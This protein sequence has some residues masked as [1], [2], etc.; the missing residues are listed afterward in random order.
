[1]H[2]IHFRKY[3]TIMVLCCL[4]I[5]AM[6]PGC[7]QGTWHKVQVPTNQFLH[8]VFFTDSLYGWA[9]GDSGTM[10]HTRDGG[11][12]WT[13]QDD[14]SDHDIM[15][16][17]FLNRNVGWASAYNFTIPPFGTQLLKTVNGGETWTREAY[18]VENIFITCINFLD[19]MN[20]WMG[21]RPHALVRTRDGG[22][23]WHQADIDTST[24]AFFPV[25]SITFFNEKYGWASG[26]MFDIAGV[27]W[28]TS[29]GGNRWFAIDVSEAPADEVHALHAFDSLNVMGAGGDPDFGY[30]VGIIRTSNSGVNWN[31]EELGMAGFAVD[32]DFRN[33]KEAW[34]PLGNRMKFIYSLDAGTTWKDVPTPDSTAIF[35]VSFPDSLHGFAVG[36]K[37]AFLRYKPA[38]VPYVSPVTGYPDGYR[39]EQNFPNPFMTSTTFSLSIP[40]VVHS[41]GL[42]FLADPLKIRISDLL[43]NTVSVIDIGKLSPGDHRVAFSRV[44]MPDGVYICCLEGGPG[45]SVLL[46]KPLRMLVL[47]IDH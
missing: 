1:M 13:I 42:S 33:K 31:Y 7:S 27:T 35:D 15:A 5:A 44:A 17:F 23:T 6:K 20:G 10:L 19:S 4:A 11:L 30:G 18:P 21:G 45:G 25:L 47:S 37:G 14:H 28:R 34:A 38:A 26:G 16:V 43:G 2:M 12:N 46:T 9:A 29:D 8:S 39:L 32:L 24:L 22:A 3:A 40:T 36:A 41:Q